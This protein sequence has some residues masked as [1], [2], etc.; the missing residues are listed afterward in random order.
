MAFAGRVANSKFGTPQNAKNIKDFGSSLFAVLIS[1]DWRLAP[2]E[3]VV[4]R[5]RERRGEEEGVLRWER[6]L[7]T[8]TQVRRV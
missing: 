8:T 4:C 7:F 5:C 2:V 6:V 3:E 1:C